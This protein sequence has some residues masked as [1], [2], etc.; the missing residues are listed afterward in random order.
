MVLYSDYLKMCTSVIL[1]YSNPIVPR[2]L[3]DSMYYYYYYYIHNRLYSPRH[4]DIA[5]LY[6][7]PVILY[8][9]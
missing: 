9:E 3:G 4:E 7:K 6:S 2:Q 5:V 1:I 8:I